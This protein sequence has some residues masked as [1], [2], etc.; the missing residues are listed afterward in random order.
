MSKA[1]PHL[2]RRRFLKKSVAAAAA[3]FMAPTIIPA[4]AIGRGGAVAPSERVVVGGIGIG[5]R[6]TYDMG[7][8]LQQPDVQFIAVCDVKESRRQAVKKLADDQYGNQ[9]C[10]MHKDFREVLDRK[11]MRYSDN[12]QNSPPKPA[13]ICIVKSLSRKTS[14]RV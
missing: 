5:G 3:A 6:G 12:W 7:C 1:S 11:P 13:R 8:F 14:P 4:S 2:P 10:S 9:D